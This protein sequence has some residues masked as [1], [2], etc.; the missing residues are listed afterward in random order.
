MAPEVLDST[1][2]EQQLLDAKQRESELFEQMAEKE[3]KL[4]DL[5]IQCAELKS[6]NPNLL[7]KVELLKDTAAKYE[8]RAE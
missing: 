6:N 7:K 5:L 2:I 3:L 8:S 4:C 1:A